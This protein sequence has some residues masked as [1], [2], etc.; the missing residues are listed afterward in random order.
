[1]E[2][3]TIVCLKADLV[4]HIRWI[5][6]SPYY[7][8]IYNHIETLSADLVLPASSFTNKWGISQETLFQDLKLPCYVYSGQSTRKNGKDRS[9]L[10]GTTG[11]RKIVFAD[12]MLCSGKVC[13]HHDNFQRWIPV[14]KFPENTASIVEELCQCDPKWKENIAKRKVIRDR[15]F[16]LI[17]YD[18]EEQEFLRFQ[19][20]WAKSL[21]Q[22]VPDNTNLANY[23]S[24]RLVLGLPA[25]QKAN[26][27]FYQSGI[28]V[29]WL[30]KTKATYD[31]MTNAHLNKYQNAQDTIKRLNGE[32]G[33]YYV[34]MS[35]VRTHFEWDGD[36]YPQAGLA[37]NWPVTGFLHLIKDYS[38]S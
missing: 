31:S 38:P 37:I 32:E 6:D 23:D 16:G 10:V 20:R 14:D 8:N 24:P 28:G 5:K 27:K 21:M 26:G 1:M 25:V 15:D 22:I 3:G 29:G 36:P 7:D 13:I 34:P 11:K 18:S 2:V 12:E 17:S 4:E 9:R 35:Y 19:M 30:L 33:T